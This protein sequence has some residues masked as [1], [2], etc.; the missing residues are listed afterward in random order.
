MSRSDVRL[1]VNLY[2]QN[3]TKMKTR[4]IT[5]ACYRKILTLLFL[6]VTFHIS[7][8]LHAQTICVD[9]VKGKAEAKGTAA[10]PLASL[11]EAVNRTNS[12]SGQEPIWIKLAPGLYTMTHEL[13]IKTAVSGRDTIAY[14]IEAMTMPDGRSWKQSKMPVIQSISSNTNIMPFTHCIGFLLSKDNVSF[15]GLKFIGNPN[16][17]VKSY[18]PIRRTDKTLTGLNLSQCYFIGERNSAPIESSLWV[19]GGGIHI[20]HCIFY[21]SKT[22]LVLNSGINDFSL[23]HSIISGSYESAIWYA[24]SG[25]P[26]TFKN[27]IITN[28][29]FVMVHPENK[30]PDYTF[31]DSYLTDNEHY[32]GAYPPSKDKQ[33]PVPV[34]VDNTSIT[35][36][37][38]H[39]S[40]K[41]ELIPSGNKVIPADYLNLSRESDGKS[42]A[43]GIF[44]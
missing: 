4:K 2:H 40:G 5:I 3:Q 31:S 14:T 41:I 21:S 15:K 26:F 12:F 24:G 22:A 33:V 35:E 32:L 7:G 16:L 36:V 37:N 42:T 34:P 11:E 6:F 9:A 30:Q 44:K 27:N 13:T 25:A 18:Y 10:D 38:I 8:N 39:K 19:S 23:T 28:C 20:D 17:N 29:R 43:A 1:R